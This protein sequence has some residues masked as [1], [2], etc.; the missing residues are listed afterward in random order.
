MPTVY[1]E[2]LDKVASSA[3]SDAAIWFAGLWAILMFIRKVSKDA[4]S[5]LDPTKKELIAKRLMGVNEN[6]ISS[7]VPNFEFVFDRFFGKKHL[8]WKCFYRSSLISMVLTSFLLVYSSVF[9]NRDDPV[10]LLFVFAI[11]ISFFFNALIDY[12]SLLETR[13]ILS[14]HIST[15]LKI[16]I[17]SMLTLILS[18]AWV[19]L[20]C[21]LF[22]FGPG[23]NFSEKI[24]MIFN[25]LIGDSKFQD[26]IVGIR[27][28]ILTSYSTSV[29]LWLHG[30]AHMC[31]R[32]LSSI[33]VIIKWLNVSESPLRAIGTTINLILFIFGVLLFPVFTII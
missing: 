22:D 23:E 3:W 5:E 16:I 20:L 7:W 11:F 8:A 2:F 24:E 27:I 6:N 15:F 10:Y 19:S 17:D 25:S 33:S 9:D 30:V 26:D 18:V 14:L 28:I 1:V 4:D 29:W 31:V 21:W 13:I 12:V 32:G